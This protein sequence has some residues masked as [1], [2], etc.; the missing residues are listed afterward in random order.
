MKN[1][2]YFH[3]LLL[4]VI[5][6]Y[7]ESHISSLG[8]NE[9]FSCAICA[10]FYQIW[11]A[12]HTISTDLSSAFLPPSFAKQHVDDTTGS[13]SHRHYPSVSRKEPRRLWDRLLLLEKALDED[14]HTLL[15]SVRELMKFCFEEQSFRRWWFYSSNPVQSC[16]DSRT[17][18]QARFRFKRDFINVYI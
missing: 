16:Q 17:R 12:I 8:I 15:F 14:T 11:M 2:S 9:T 13:A 4:C 6:S 18:S 5:S 3:E 7:G 1:I 10:I